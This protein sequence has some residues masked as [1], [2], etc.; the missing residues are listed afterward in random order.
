MV[1]ILQAVFLFLRALLK[2][3]FLIWFLAWRTRTV[4]YVSDAACNPP[5]LGPIGG[6]F[7]TTAVHSITVAHPTTTIEVTTS[8]IAHETI[9]TVWHS[10]PIVAPEKQ[11]ASLI[12]DENICNFPHLFTTASILPPSLNVSHGLDLEKWKA[13]ARQLQELDSLSRENREAILNRT[14]PYQYWRF[15]RELDDLVKKPLEFTCTTLRRVQD[16][17]IDIALDTVESLDPSDRKR[18]IL[19]LLEVVGKDITEYRKTIQ[20][21]SIMPEW[22]RW[23]PELRSENCPGRRCML[24]GDE[25]IDNFA[26]DTT[27]ALLRSIRRVQLTLNPKWVDKSEPA[28]VKRMVRRVKRQIKDYV[29]QYDTEWLLGVLFKLLLW[30]LEKTLWAVGK[31]IVFFVMVVGYV[32]GISYEDVMNHGFGPMSHQRD[33]EPGL[34]W[35]LFIFIF[36]ICCM[37]TLQDVSDLSSGEIEVLD[38]EEI[39]IHREITEI[40]DQEEIMDQEV[41]KKDEAKKDEVKKDEVK[42]DEVKKEV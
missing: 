7:A 5:T 16:R 6:P 4:D 10:P 23:A 22:A 39:L 2:A 25:S 40:T 15:R 34:E 11:N 28:P 14:R 35:K 8:E 31:L 1:A 29:S 17:L 13:A 41:A 36:L 19:D 18:L 42:K 12:I 38:P 3:E 24:I 37:L 27:K 33:F 26:Y 21:R 32:T 30:T 20:V 9:Q